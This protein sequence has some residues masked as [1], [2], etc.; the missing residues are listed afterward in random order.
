M[1]YLLSQLSNKRKNTFILFLLNLLIYV[2]FRPPYFENLIIKYGLNFEI[3]DSNFQSALFDAFESLEYMY[4]AQVGR[5]KVDL[6][7]I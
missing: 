7:L 1:K 5:S 2:N 6:K 4:D 3:N